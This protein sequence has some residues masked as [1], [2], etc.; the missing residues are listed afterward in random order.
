MEKLKTGNGYIKYRH[1]DRKHK[2]IS[3]DD[4]MISGKFTISKKNIILY[5]YLCRVCNSWH[6]THKKTKY[7]VI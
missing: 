7:K 6:L 1:C 3:I 4:A 5:T 2:F